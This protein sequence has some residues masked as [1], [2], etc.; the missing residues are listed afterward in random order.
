MGHL[1][2]STRIEF[3]TIVI[4]NTP[5]D[6]FSQRGKKKFPQIKLI[7]NPKPLGFG[8][9]NNQG[10]RQARGDKILILNSDCYVF[11]DT[12]AKCYQLPYEVVGCQLVGA[13]G[14]VLP[15]TG[16]FPTLRRVTQMM[17]F[18]DNMPIVRKFI[19]TIHIRDVSR[20]TKTQAV[21]WVQG[22]FILLKREV[23]QKVG[24]FDE[25]FQMYGEEVE[26]QYRIKQAGY[27][28][29]YYPAS[30]AVHLERMSVKSLD[31]SF[32]GEMQG[33]RYYFKKHRPI[34]EQKLLPAVLVFGCA[35]RIPAWAVWGRW[36]LVKA[37]LKILPKVVS[38]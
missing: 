25:N 21:D 23:Y 7:D 37:Y 14:A 6:G 30:R 9:N 19:D 36:D 31:P 15:S 5:Q 28:I 17:L 3:E 32:I 4:N 33:Y 22:A 29:W 11:P 2:K 24:G 13:T 12:L 35:I 38:F 18:V 34:W 26:W 16:Y 8:A 10:M 1:Y 20:L 27:Q